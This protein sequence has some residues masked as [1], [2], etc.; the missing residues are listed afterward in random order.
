MARTGLTGRYWLALLKEGGR[1]TVAEA[2]KLV[3]D[4]DRVNAR[5][6]LFGMAESGSLHK[7]APGDDKRA[8]RFGV[9]PDC[10]VPM[11]V[12]ISDILACNL[13][14]GE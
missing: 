3:G 10:K 9:T 13:Q 8:A 14:A 2:E 1:L 12:T 7:Y 6:I 5:V 11:G 4:G